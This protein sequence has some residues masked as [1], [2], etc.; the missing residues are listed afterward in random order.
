MSADC[1]YHFD[2]KKYMYQTECTATMSSN[3]SAFYIP[4]IDE[5]LWLMGGEADG[6]M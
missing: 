1:S 6:D 5:G 2:H 4:G 3:N